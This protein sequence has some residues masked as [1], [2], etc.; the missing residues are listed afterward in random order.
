MSADGVVEEVHGEKVTVNL[1]GLRTTVRWSDLRD[2]TITTPDHSKGR[3]NPRRAPSK[4]ASATRDEDELPPRTTGNTLDLRGLHV[5]DA[6]VQVE[7]F[8]DQGVLHGWTIGFLLH[9][10]GTGKL[11]AGL[12]AWL[13]SSHYVERME[14]AERSHGG[15][16]VTVVWIR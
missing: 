7:R 11:K 1:G 13:P 15:D 10:H 12:R 14:A 5:E 4:A 8:L 9:G 3:Y 2:R 6:I 16:G